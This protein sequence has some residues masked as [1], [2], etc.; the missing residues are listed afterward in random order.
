[1]SGRKKVDKC[2]ISGCGKPHL[3]KGFCT[4]HYKRARNQK[5]MDALRTKMKAR[6]SG[7]CEIQDC[8]EPFYSKGMCK[9]HY[10]TVRLQL[11]AKK[12]DD[13]DSQSQITSDEPKEPVE[14]D[15]R[16]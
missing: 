12:K 8:F 5:D 11:V 2:L 13:L 4:G 1:M 14:P 7:E 15:G 10:E 3:A 9:A 16:S 6:E